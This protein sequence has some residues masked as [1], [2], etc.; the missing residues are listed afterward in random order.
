VHTVTTLTIAAWPDP[1]ID[2][3]GHDPRSDYVERF[4]LPTLGPTSLLLLRRIASHLDREPDGCTFDVAD[5]SQSMGLGAREGTS[6]PLFRSLDRLMQFELACSPASRTYAVRRTVPPVTRRHISRLPLSLQRAHEVW[7]DERLSTSPLE[8]ARTRARRLAFVLFEQGDDLSGV[9]H[10]LLGVGFHPSICRESAVW[11]YE[12]HRVAFE[13]VADASG[14][15]A[16]PA[17]PSR[18]TAA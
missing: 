3:L 14:G 15:L 11:A 2:T 16:A 4:W 8:H 6:S 18:D 13:A 12:R 10:A 7:L 5:L 1:I 9:E 17:A